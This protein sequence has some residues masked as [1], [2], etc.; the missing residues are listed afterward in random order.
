MKDNRFK[1][2]EN[3]RIMGTYKRK[4][5]N[6]KDSGTYLLQISIEK[7]GT[8]FPDYIDIKIDKH[9]LYDDLRKVVSGETERLYLAHGMTDIDIYRNKTTNKYCIRWSPNDSSYN[10][11]YF[12]EENF[13]LDFVNALKPNTEKQY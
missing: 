3:C 2:F 7:E 8:Y 12:E 9:N 11:M 5:S 1:E 6:I 10:Y 13:L 4:L